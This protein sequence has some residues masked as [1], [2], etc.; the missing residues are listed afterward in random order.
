M[1]ISSI[2]AVVCLAAAFPAAS[3]TAIH[4]EG[5]WW[6]RTVSGSEALATVARLQVSLRG[7]V[8]VTSGPNPELSW[9]LKTRTTARTEAEARRLLDAFAVKFSTAG[10]GGRALLFV[11]S[12]RGEAGLKLT[13]PATVRELS[14]GTGEGNVEALGVAG[15]I[16]LATGAGDVKADRVRG[17]LTARTGGGDIVM[18][19]I[20]G[21]ARCSTSAGDI[22]ARLIHGEAVLETGGGD[23][24]VDAVGGPARA[25]TVGG[26]VQIIRAGSGVIAS[27]GGG[28]IEIGEAR[29]LVELRNSG[30]PVHVGSAHGVRCETASG[31]IRLTNVSGVLRASTFIGSI[32]AQLHGAGATGDS[33]LT[34]GRGDITVFIPSNVG[35]KI[36]AENELSGGIRRIISEFPGIQARVHGAQVVAEGDINGGGPLLRISG[37]GG[38]IFIKRQ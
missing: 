25:S 34:T 23:V 13:V 15:E 31:A 6:V 5:R 9:V 38:T 12:G 28:P 26:K 14:I 1:R 29:G 8:Y 32:I 18:G 36:R 7:D 21:M 30:G 35:V 16:T 11:H 2:L 24:T 10:S 4:R 3:Q 20:G 33:F 19:E 37:T 17:N 22:T 27:T